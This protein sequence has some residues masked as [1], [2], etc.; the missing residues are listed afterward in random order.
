[1]GFLKTLCDLHRTNEPLETLAWLVWVP[2]RTPEQPCRPLRAEE[3][4]TDSFAGIE[5]RRCCWADLGL[6]G[7][8]VKPRELPDCRLQGPEENEL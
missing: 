5:C 8:S 3:A 4:C 2:S 6:V 7:G 1:M